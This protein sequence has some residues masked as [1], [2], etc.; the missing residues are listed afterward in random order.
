MAYIPLILNKS[1]RSIV[2]GRSGSSDMAYAQTPF[3]PCRSTF[4][5]EVHVLEGLIF[6]NVFVLLNLFE[7]PI[8]N[9]ILQIDE[10]AF[11]N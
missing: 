11:V 2:L 4:K 8:F 5:S 3:N 9:I 7:F 1:S 6:Q 10:L